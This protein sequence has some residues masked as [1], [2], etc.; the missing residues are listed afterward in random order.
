[1]KK[2]SW[3]VALLIALSLAF[4]G[5][6]GDSGGGGDS[7][8]P[9]DPNNPDNPGGGG[10]IVKTLTIKANEYG[11]DD[12]GVAVEGPT[13]T[14]GFQLTLKGDAA[15]LTTVAAGDVYKLTIKFTTNRDVGESLRTGIVDTDSSVNY[16]KPLT[17]TGDASDIVFD[18]VEA[19]EVVEKTITFTGLSAGG[20]SLAST[21]LMFQTDMEPHTL[22]DLVLSCTVYEFVK[23]E[24]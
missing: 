3:I 18:E 9:D 22:G 23:V 10:P 15:P 21:A 2:Y 20:T 5:C 11:K 1:M 6:P 17:W 14:H 4:I 8:D 24:E 12:D 7:N 16:W 19:G 13:A